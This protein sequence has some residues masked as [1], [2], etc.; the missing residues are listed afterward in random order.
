[1][2]KPGFAY[3]CLRVL[4]PLTGAVAAIHVLHAATLDRV[5]QYTEVPFRSRNVPAALD[6]YRIAFVC[7]AHGISER[8]LNDAVARLNSGPID[9]LLLG[10]D[11]HHD[12][13][14]A[15]L[16]LEILSGVRASDG[17]FGVE[18]NHDDRA[19]LFPAMKA[20]GITPLLNEGARIRDGLFLAGT[21]DMKSVGPGPCIASAVENAE[22]GD[23]VLLLTHN[24]D[25]TMRRP[26]AGIDLVLS[27][28]THGGHVTLFGLWAPALTLSRAV[29][30]YRQR[31]MSGWAKS[32]DGVPVFVSRGIGGYFPRVFAR[33]QV[34]IVTLRSES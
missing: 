24:A 16:S 10:G 11:F 26:T 13:Q 6:G 33:P 21:A 27:G 22:P 29:T 30:H 3:G 12:P 17:I 34:V 20:R 4:L 7:D 9:L 28:H 19:Y 5:V 18:G 15:A 1:M 8:T 14:R 2:P 31:F 25:L 32:R 23:F